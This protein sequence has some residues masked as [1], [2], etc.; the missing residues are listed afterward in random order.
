MEWLDLSEYLVRDP[1]YESHLVETADTFFLQTKAPKYNADK[2]FWADS[3]G[4]RFAEDFWKTCE[5][6]MDTLKIC[7]GFDIRQAKAG[8]AGASIHMGLQ[9]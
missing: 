4:G 1:Y 6:E 2:Q 5:K 8:N 7:K 3:F 9:I